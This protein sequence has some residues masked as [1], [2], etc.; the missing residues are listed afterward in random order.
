M[1]RNKIKKIIRSN[2]N[3]ITPSGFNIIESKIKNNEGEILE[4]EKENGMKK[5]FVLFKFALTFCV[6]LI[7]TVIGLKTYN[8]NKVSSVISIDINPSLEVKV[9]EKNEVVTVIPKNDDAKNLLINVNVKGEDYNVAV[10]TIMEEIIKD[11]YIDGTRN[12]VL[13]TVINDDNNDAENIRVNVVNEISELL[14]N[15]NLGINVSV[16]S[17][18]ATN[19]EKNEVQK[20]ANENNISVGKAIYLNKMLETNN[21]YDYT[22]LAKLTIGELNV[23]NNLEN[24]TVDVIK[25]EVISKVNVIDDNTN[26]NVTTDNEGATNVNVKDND[27]NVKV[28]NSTS[29][30]G[31]TVKDNDTSVGVD[32]GKDK[33]EVNVKD[34]DILS[35][36]AVKVI[37]EAASKS[38]TV[39]GYNITL[40]KDNN[41]YVV[42][43]TTKQGM[44]L[45]YYINAKTG[46]I[47]D[48]KIK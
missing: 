25:N 10:N 45:E 47:E 37:V 24:A 17:Q 39:N 22:D 35:E 43:M 14:N 38:V 13:V 46:V 20:D 26:V 30:T 18:V 32:V 3:D 34:N 42:S 21:N 7:C 48:F 11:G 12:A 15:T 2:F 5:E 31:V 28:N 27:T 41:Q 1:K 6:L 23:I 4:M 19:S 33:V 16:L 36:T 44:T 8:I 9:N 40:N 29:N